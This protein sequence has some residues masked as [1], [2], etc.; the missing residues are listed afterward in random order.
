MGQKLRSSKVH[1]EQVARSQSRDGDQ[2]PPILF[3]PRVGAGTRNGL[4]IGPPHFKDH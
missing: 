4:S 1:R 2:L 3:N